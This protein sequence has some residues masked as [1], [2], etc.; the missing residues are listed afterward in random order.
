LNWPNN[1]FFGGNF[2]RFLFS[3]PGSTAE[4]LS[5]GTLHTQRCQRLDKVLEWHLK[6]PLQLA[7]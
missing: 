4:L 7:A 5:S 2:V 1:Q 6:M 3:Q